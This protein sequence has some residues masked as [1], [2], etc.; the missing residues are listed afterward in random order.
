M[1][2]KSLRCKNCDKIIPDIVAS[3]EDE[4]CSEECFD[5]FI[6]KKWKYLRFPCCNERIPAPLDGVAKAICPCGGKKK[7]YL[8]I[9]I[10]EYNIEIKNK[11]IWELKK[12]V[13]LLGATYGLLCIVG[14]Y[15]DTLSDKEILA[16]LEG[17]NKAT[18]KEKGD[19]K[20]KTLLLKCPDCKKFIDLGEKACEVYNASIA[21]QLDKKCPYCDLIIIESDTHEADYRIVNAS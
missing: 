5:D 11:I 7:E 18:Q 8:P 14:S 4:Y 2:D 17:W 10:Y 16:E 3:W 19:I 15:M 12:S 21:F 9:E 6:E 1:K 13:E 20:E